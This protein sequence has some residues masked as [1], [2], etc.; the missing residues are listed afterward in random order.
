MRK[1][2]LAPILTEEQFI[3]ILILEVL[4]CQDYLDE[5]NPNNTEV[6][7]IKNLLEALIMI[8]EERINK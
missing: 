5:V 6:I 8:Y 4:K 1:T 7:I 2:T 3:D